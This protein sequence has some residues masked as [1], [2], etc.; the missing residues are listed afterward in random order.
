MEPLARFFSFCLCRYSRR[1]LLHAHLLLPPVHILSNQLNSSKYG[2]GLA[3]L[4]FPS[5]ARF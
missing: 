2:A 4:N 1:H 5:R 3:R